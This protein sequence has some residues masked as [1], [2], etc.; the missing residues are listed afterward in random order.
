MVSKPISITT[1]SE[2][3]S[4][5]LIKWNSQFL[6]YDWSGELIRKPF[7]DNVDHLYSEL[8]SRADIVLVRR[9]FDY[10]MASGKKQYE[11]LDLKTGLSNFIIV[12]EDRQ[13]IGVLRD[14][15][16]LLICEGKCEIS[17]STMDVFDATLNRG[18][19]LI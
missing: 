7:L 16:H 1:N 11:L 13:E 3:E 10:N 18:H 12:Q 8:N 19:F 17:T 6:V 15:N 4:F 2:D 9:Y 5:F 14:I